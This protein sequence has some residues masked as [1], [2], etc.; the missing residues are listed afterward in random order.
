MK[1]PSFSSQLQFNLNAES[2]FK[3]DQAACF[4]LFTSSSHQ[5]VVGSVAPVLLEPEEPA[6]LLTI[7]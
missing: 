5:R 4:S 7:D 2:R 6:L 1:S 3:H